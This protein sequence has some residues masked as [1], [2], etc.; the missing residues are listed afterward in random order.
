MMKRK[1][2]EMMTAHKKDEGA[3]TKTH[4]RP[5]LEFW[6]REDFGGTPNEIFPYN[7]YD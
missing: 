1:T 3:S 7:R 2:I 5:M 6:D 4:D